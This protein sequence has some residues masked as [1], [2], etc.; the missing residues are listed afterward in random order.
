MN[1][2]R[3]IFSASAALCLFFS[4]S[5]FGQ[6]SF[7]PIQPFAG[8]PSS[9]YVAAPYA[10]PQANVIAPGFG[11]VGVAPAPGVIGVTPQMQVP[12][13]TVAPSLVGVP[14]P[15]AVPYQP[16]NIQQGCGYTPAFRPCFSN[17]G[18]GRNNYYGVYP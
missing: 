16:M 2:G 14:A 3:W 5:A 17:P 6:A 4:S 11:Q 9:V 12:A 7:G 15:V 13:A 18:C 1:G 8:A 10:G